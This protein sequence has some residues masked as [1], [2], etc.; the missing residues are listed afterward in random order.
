MPRRKS[1]SNP[2]L[3]NND[4]DNA[5]VPSSAPTKQQWETMPI[6]S[7]FV[8]TDKEGK[9][10]MFAKGDVATILPHG[11]DPGDELALNDY[12]IGR[13]RDVRAVMHEDGTNDVW[14]KIQWYY[15]PRDVATVVKSF[16]PSACGTNELIFS[17]HYDIVSHDAFNEVIR[18]SRFDE[19]K[20]EQEYIGPEQLFCRYTCEVS[21]RVVRPKPGLDSC[22]C[23][24]PYSTSDSNSIVHICPRP[25]CRR[26]FHETCLL[27][28]KVNRKKQYVDNDKSSRD[29]RVLAASPDE[30]D[31][32]LERLV[33]EQPK[34]KRRRSS[35]GAAAS[36][37]EDKNNGDVERDLPAA[38]A[39]IPDLL[40]KIAQ[41]PIIRGGSFGVVGN[42][43]PVVRARRMVYTALSQNGMIPEGWEEA[44][45]GRWPG[46]AKVFGEEPEE[47]SEGEKVKEETGTDTVFV[48]PATTGRK[49][50]AGKKNMGRGRKEKVGRNDTRKARFAIPALLCPNCGAAI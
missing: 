17:D 47:D 45:L 21:L 35:R 41:H 50:K 34:K 6:Y 23:S 29:L 13:I 40:L 14:T 33:S 39:K 12:W 24:Q 18:M 4:P 32:D 11:I 25:S 7:S 20:L 48:T 3:P 44:V 36:L 31:L 49:E 38:L 19:K 43:A 5:P 30:D 1:A 8:V 46:I 42:I 15:T 10:H 37:N 9:N 16:N 26:S 2:N 28:A 27:N 22:I